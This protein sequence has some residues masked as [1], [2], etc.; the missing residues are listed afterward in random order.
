MDPT[1][2]LHSLQG[3]KAF[4]MDALINSIKSSQ[5]QHVREQMVHENASQEYSNQKP[6][7]S[8][9]PNAGIS[10]SM[11]QPF[12]P[13]PMLA[14]HQHFQPH[15]MP[16]QMYM[17]P[18]MIQRPELL[19]QQMFNQEQQSKISLSE[20]ARILA[21]SVQG[22]PELTATEFLS[23][24]D[25]IGQEEITL[26]E[27]GSVTE[28]SIL[29]S[30]V[31][32]VHY[33][34]QQQSQPEASKTEEKAEEKDDLEF[35]DYLAREWDQMS[36]DDQ[37]AYSWL[38]DPTTDPVHDEYR[39]SEDNPLKEVENPFEEGMKKLEQG[40]IPSAVLLFEAACQQ[41]ETNVAAW[42]YLGTT[43]AKNEHDT[44][45]IRAL[46]RCVALDPVNLTAH[47]ALAVS[48]T[49]ESLQRQAC[50]SL[51]DW[52]RNNPK[53]ADIVA[54]SFIEQN[55][56]APRTVVSSVISKGHFNQAKNAY[57]AAA[58]QQPNGPIDPDVQGGLGVL[59]NLS[60]EYDK[61]ID[62]F[63][64][65]IE[66]RPEDPLLW[67]RLGAT[68]ANGNKSEEAVQAYRR[69]LELSPGFIR[70]RFN[71]GISCIN[72]RAHNEAVE[73]FLAVLN[74]QAAGKG[75]KGESR[76]AMSNN[77]W[78]SLRMVLSIMGRQD[79]YGA[80]ELR[81]LAKLNQEFNMNVS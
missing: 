61:A 41:D 20:E 22:D 24:I 68:L 66:A 64:A 14:N 3:A 1:A 16:P 9:W 58:R 59:F 80:V 55:A 32:E 19:T 18:H 13:R 27:D 11:S 57:I 52:I 79:M 73:H 56:D 30:D 39:F 53:Y 46:K 38:D 15:F 48:Y 81:D 47:M 62:C 45:A 2:S 69:A 51:G 23:F 4:Q 21:R 37:T 33:H 78:T 75:L 54:G 25:R 42:Q 29:T 7:T 8:H 35:W 60:G 76:S 40:D 6:T 70:S 34:E 77:V 72:L 17:Q 10:N 63:R 44:A 74:M 43:Q 12:I 50:D 5:S 31:K 67:N 65:A 49:N 71:L 26:R 36:K 28:N